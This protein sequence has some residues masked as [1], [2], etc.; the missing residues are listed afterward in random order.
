MEFL[1]VTARMA[2]DADWLVAGKTVQ[3]CAICEAIWI[4]STTRYVQAD[5]REARFRSPTLRQSPLPAY[6]PAYLLRDS[7]QQA[8]HHRR[9]C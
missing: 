8:V 5:M 1:G 9:K 2:K 7:S 4:T 6:R 3:L